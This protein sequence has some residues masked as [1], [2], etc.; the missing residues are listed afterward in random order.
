MRRRLVNVPE[1]AVFLLL[2]SS[3]I[4]RL[5][6]SS[7][8][9]PSVLMPS[10]KGRAL[11]FSTAATRFFF[12]AGAAFFPFEEVEAVGEGA[13]S[14]STTVAEGAGGR[15]VESNAEGEVKKEAGRTDDA[16][17]SKWGRARAGSTR[18]PS[19]VSEEGEGP[20]RALKSTVDAEG[21]VPERAEFWRAFEGRAGVL[22]ALK[23]DSPPRDVNLEADLS[24]SMRVPP[25]FSSK[26]GAGS[27]PKSGESKSNA[28]FVHCSS[29]AWSTF[30]SQG[31][32]T[33][34]CSARPSKREGR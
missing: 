7:S 26:R 22:T 10:G 2:L 16:L 9:I 24:S 6:S 12:C 32:E 15:E 21:S 23:R 28:T 8:V 25:F 11:T 18:L 4:A 5:F 14:S 29:W 19:N 30:P 13:C 27:D 33:E 31:N 1:A 17:W 34:Q 20:R 3:S